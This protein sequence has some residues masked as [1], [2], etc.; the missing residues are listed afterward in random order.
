MPEVTVDEVLWAAFD[1]SG[2][3]PTRGA[4]SIKLRR[5]KALF[6]ITP[7]MCAL[8][9]NIMDDNQCH[10]SGGRLQHLLWSI[11]FLKQYGTE[12]MNR[13]LTRVDEKTFRKWIW[14]YIPRLAFDLHV[15]RNASLLASVHY[16]SR[17]SVFNF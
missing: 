6:G 7:H 8:I 14:L 9:W 2:D 4:A 11:M 17:S 13:A 10:P 16:C 15:V 12:A 3:D 5:F 1:I